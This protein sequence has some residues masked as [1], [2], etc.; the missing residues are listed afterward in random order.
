M[1]PRKTRAAA[2][3]TATARVETKP[4]RSS[5]RG[6]TADPEPV[7]EAAQVEATEESATTAPKRATRSTRSTRGKA[8]APATEA[9]IVAEAPETAEPSKPARRANKREA[10]TEVEDSP[11]A[12]KASG[13]LKAKGESK[14]HAQAILWDEILMRNQAPATRK[15]K[16]E[17]LEEADEATKIEDVVDGNCTNYLNPGSS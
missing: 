12:K 8:A 16:V 10:T 3:T 1:A 7:E 14:H 13:G 17:V 11:K 5:K 2:S 9:P 15:R 4:T 6:T